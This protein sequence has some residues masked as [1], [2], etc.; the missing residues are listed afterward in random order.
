MTAILKQL[1]LFAARC[2]FQSFNLLQ[3]CKA[4]P[5]HSLDQVSNSDLPLHFRMK[6]RLGKVGG[7]EAS[8]QT[9]VVMTCQTVERS[10]RAAF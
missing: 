3:M 6:G 2:C 9:Q 5:A 4:V 8:Q 7:V 1:S 10:D